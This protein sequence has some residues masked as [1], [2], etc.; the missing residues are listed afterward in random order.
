MISVWNYLDTPQDLVLTLFYSGG[1]YKI[2]LH[3][4]AR[5]TYNLDLMK[6]VGSRVPDSDGNLI[7]SN[8]SSGSGLLSSRD[9]GIAEMSVAINVATYN[10]RNATCGN[11]CQ[12]CNGV[13]ELAIIPIGASVDVGKTL[14]LYAQETMNTG[15][16]DTVITTGWSVGS[17]A[18]I[19]S[20][21]VVTGVSAGLPQVTLTKSNLPAPAGY[22]CT[23]PNG[24]C[25]PPISITHSDSL[26][27]GQQTPTSMQVSFD[28][29]NV[30]GN[31][32]QVPAQNGVTR[33]IVYQLK[34]DTQNAGYSAVQESFGNL[35]SNTCGNG[36]PTPSTCGLHYVDSGGKFTD[37]LA[38]NYC[39]STANNSCGL[40]ILP[41]HWQT[42]T[43]GTTSTLGSPNYIIDWN[44]ITINGATQ[45]SG[46]TP[47]P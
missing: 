34:V 43:N 30:Q 22:V 13:L 41:D 10:V 20:N 29:G 27:V 14:Q 11:Q 16:I 40:S 46:G 8:V 28:P 25:P 47:I 2:P 44:S 9:G 12:T 5:K 4:D 6:L 21:G 1:Q 36:N 23:G 24:G 39:S 33:Q 19:D 37:D 35:S 42:C 38:T 15:E 17:G 3:L 26:A 7:P 45:L 31:S 18:S 32:C